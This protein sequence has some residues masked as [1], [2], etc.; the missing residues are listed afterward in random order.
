MSPPVATIVIPTFNRVALVKRAIDTALQQ[1]V[2]CEV[3]VSDHGS[4]D[5]TPELVRAYGER[6]IYLRR[7]QDRGPHFAWLDGVVNASADYVHFTFDDDWIDPSYMEKCLRLFRD[8]CAFVVSA[9]EVHEEDG[10]TIPL[11]VDEFQTGV[12]DARKIEAKLLR[13]SLTISPACAVF[14]K[15]DVLPAMLMGELPTVTVSYHGV[16]N[17]LLMYLLPLLRYPKFGFLNE[18]AAHLLAHKGSITIDAASSKASN[19]ALK[20]AY[21][22]VKRYYFVLK[23][24]R[25]VP[26]G[27]AMLAWARMKGRAGRRFGRL[28]KAHPRSSRS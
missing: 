9:A 7:E 13:M 16:G 25:R 3:I 20:D 15:K 24:S 22:D 11:Y 21:R 27:S 2:P 14:R 5:G 18:K 10:R 12:H 4:T 26:L 28:F 6:V 1:T 8:D 19:K 17:D 23:F